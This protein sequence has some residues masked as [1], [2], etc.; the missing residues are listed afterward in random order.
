MTDAK[1]ADMDPTLFDWQPHSQSTKAHTAEQL[2]AAELCDGCPVMQQCARFAYEVRPSEVI[3]AGIA[4]PALERDR[5]KSAKLAYQR[6]ARKLGINNAPPSR[7]KM[8]PGPEKGSKA[9]YIKPRLTHCSKNHE[10]TGDNVYV[11][12]L[13]DGSEKR[14]C[15][16]CKREAARRT[17]QRQQERKKSA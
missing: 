17:W 1:C 9:S 13:S 5:S 3:Y 4:F 7:K 15:N 10:L 8:K 6:L 12:T 14:I 16:T 11:I 2:R